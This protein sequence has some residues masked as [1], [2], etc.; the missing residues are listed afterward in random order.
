MYGQG[1]EVISYNFPLQNFPIKKGLGRILGTLGFEVVSLVAPKTFVVKCWA[2]AHDMRA[3]AF[4]AFVVGHFVIVLK[5]STTA[6]PDSVDA[7]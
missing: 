1:Y 5:I 3:S 7:L 4:R 2:L 6:S